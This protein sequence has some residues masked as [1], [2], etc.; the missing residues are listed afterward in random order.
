MERYHYYCKNIIKF[1]FRVL[2]TLMY[3]FRYYIPNPFVVYAAIACV[4]VIVS[5][6][7]MVFNWDML[8]GARTITFEKKYRKEYA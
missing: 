7:Y 8:T 4:A 3:P 6:I 5:Q 2:N 1:F